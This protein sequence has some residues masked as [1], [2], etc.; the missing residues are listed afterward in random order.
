M[1][2]GGEGDEFRRFAV[3]SAAVETEAGHTLEVG[4]EGE[5]FADGTERHVITLEAG[6][7]ALGNLTSADARELAA[8]LLAAADL[9]D[10]CASSA[11]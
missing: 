8:A 9:Q 1:Q 2:D 4:V 5:Q 11:A 3:S 6:I 10:G 7:D